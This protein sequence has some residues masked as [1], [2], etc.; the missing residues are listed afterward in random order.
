MTSTVLHAVAVFALLMVA[1]RA[2]GKREMAQLSP[3]DL[4]VLVIM[5]DVVAEAITSEDTSLT[6]AS[7]VVATLVCLNV[8]LA[9]I[10]WRWPRTRPALEGTAVVV[11]RDGVPDRTAMDRERLS[12]DDLRAAARTHGIRRLDEVDLAVLETDGSFSFFTRDG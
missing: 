2:M 8:L 5:G 4:I 12:F 10:A 9:R 7:I 6:G 3:F 1:I 11:L